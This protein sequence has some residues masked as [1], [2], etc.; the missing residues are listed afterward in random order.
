MGLSLPKR[1]T[2]EVSLRHN[3]QVDCAFRADCEARRPCCL[4]SLLSL[5]HHRH[6]STVQ[7]TLMDFNYPSTSNTTTPL[8]HYRP[9]PSPPLAPAPNAESRRSVAQHSLSHSLSS[10]SLL[11]TNLQHRLSLVEE[12]DSTALVDSSYT[13]ERGMLGPSLYGTGLPDPAAA[14]RIQSQQQLPLHQ[15]YWITGESSSVV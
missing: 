14:P 2:I 13:M 10:T 12:H 4:S 3:E 1:Q 15:P 8:Y 5:L 7:P 11:A 6:S 9:L